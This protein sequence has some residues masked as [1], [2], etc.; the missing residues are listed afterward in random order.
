MA[1]SVPS[2]P[3]VVD[4][5]PE[6]AQ[7]LAILLELEGYQV[8]TVHG[9]AQAIRTINRIDID[10][11]FLDIMLPDISGL[12]FC[13]YVRRDPVLA[14]LPI[15]VLSARTRPEDIREGLEAGANKYFTKP[16]LKE[17]LLAALEEELAA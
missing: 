15:I 1:M 4:D 17:S 11:V 6:T 13:R 7:M 12:E 16:W 9:T 3:L 14:E 2:D 5:E 8:T 10:L